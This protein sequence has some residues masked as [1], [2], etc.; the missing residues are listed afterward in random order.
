[1]YCGNKQNISHISY[2]W[3]QNWITMLLNALPCPDANVAQ[4]LHID[5]IAK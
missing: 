4:K 3:N 2:I 5:A 1:M